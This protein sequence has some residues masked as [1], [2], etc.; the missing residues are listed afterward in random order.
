VRFAH[1]YG[2]RLEPETEECA[3]RAIAEGFLGRV[4]RERLRNELLLILQEPGCGGALRMLADLGGLE[5]IL[6]GVSLSP[7][8][9]A[10]LDAAD[11]L[12]EAQPGISA[13]SRLWLVKLLV[14]L[15]RLP[16]SEGAGLVKRLRLKRA[17]S[18]ACLRV[19]AG[20]RIAHDLVTAPRADPAAIVSQL[21]D[22][23]PE[24]LLLLHL[25]GGGDRVATYWREWRRIRLDITGADVQALGVPPGPRIGR[26]LERVLAARLTGA[27][28]DRASQLELAR[29]YAAQQEE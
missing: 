3:R 9:M 28:P 10:L 7:D 15:H 27:A 20:W 2:F 4:S 14:L 17:E 13:E 12:P 26:I 11:G 6:P 25:L 21:R 18:Q 16:L 22:W 5:Q 19:L 8:L 24:G 1:R 29:R 23:P